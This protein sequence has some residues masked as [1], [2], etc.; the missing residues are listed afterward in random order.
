MSGHKG[1]VKITP[2]LLLQLM[3]REEG[4]EKD[5]HQVN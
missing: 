3:T 1:L 4:L 2:R 5:N